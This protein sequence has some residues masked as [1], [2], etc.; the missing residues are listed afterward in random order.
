VEQT[1]LL[2]SDPHLGCVGGGY[3]HVDLNSGTI[4]ARSLSFD[5]I[6]FLERFPLYVPFP[7]TFMA[8]RK[9]A[10]AAVGGYPEWDD[11]EEMG[12]LAALL[13][14]NWKIGSVSKIMGEHFIYEHSYFERQHGF[15][16][17]RWRNLKR[18]L[19]M[20]RRYNSVRATYMMMLARFAY[21]FL[22]PSLKSMARRAAGYA[23]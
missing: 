7:H 23:T 12:L 11:Y 15:T 13:D 21:N 5:S 18:Q 2:D 17:R 8:F 22:P 4:E 9:S 16:R 10:V 14:G 3:R 6:R 20:K 19:A 1:A